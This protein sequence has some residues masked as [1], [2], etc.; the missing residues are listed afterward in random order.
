[1]CGR[2]AMILAFD[3]DVVPDAERLAKEV[4]VKVEAMIMMMMMTMMMMMMMM[5]VVVVVVIGIMMV[6]MMIL[7]LIFIGACELIFSSRLIERITVSMWTG[8]HSQDHL[9]LVRRLHRSYGGREA[10]EEAG[11]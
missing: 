3:V 4:N 7:L 2:Y 5:V 11:A 8:L 9:P 6:M 1:M 10:E